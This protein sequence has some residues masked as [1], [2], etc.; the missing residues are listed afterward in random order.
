MNYKLFDGDALNIFH[1]INEAFFRRAY[2]IF[3]PRN[4][5]YIS[6]NDGMCNK[7]VLVQRDTLINSNTIVRLSRNN[8]TEKE[9]EIIKAIKAANK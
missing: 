5:M 4:A 2:E 7:A 1:I 3:N 8:Y 6:R 9:L